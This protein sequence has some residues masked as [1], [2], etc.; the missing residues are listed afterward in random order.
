MKVLDNAFGIHDRALA[1]RGER[2]EVLS[3]NI[4]NADTP[5][6]KARDLDFAKVLAGAAER[7]QALRVTHPRHFRVGQ[8]EDRAGLLYRVPFN[9]SSDGNTV[10]ISVEQARYGQATADYQATLQFLERRI[11]GIRKA[12]KG[13]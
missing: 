5:H 2:L 12:L 7:E 3:R 4:A 8:G 11:G 6:F 13:E 9:A 1:V 10:E